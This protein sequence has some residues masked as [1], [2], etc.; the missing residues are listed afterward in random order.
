MAPPTRVVLSLAALV[1]LLFNSASLGGAQYRPTEP[2]TV[3]LILDGAD[4]SALYHRQNCPLVIKA[5][6]TPKMALAVA[7]ARYFRPH[8]LCIAGYEAEPPCDSASPPPRANPSNTKL[9]STMVG[10]TAPE[11]LT[12]LGAPSLVDRSTWHYDNIGLKLEFT[13]GKVSSEID[14][15][16][17]ETPVKGRSIVPKTNPAAPSLPPTAPTAAKPTSLPQPTA[18]CRDGTYSYSKSR[19]G[20]CSGHGGVARWMG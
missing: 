9:H 16:R 3:Y 10:L 19:S 6:S 4:T 15:G 5:G 13:N 11:V 17:I 8:C 1:A 2:Q 12:A 14:T 20:T 7:K 18:V